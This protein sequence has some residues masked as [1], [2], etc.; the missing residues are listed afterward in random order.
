[1]NHS[2]E[3]TPI[4]R[5]LGAMN[6][7]LIH[8]AIDYHLWNELPHLH[9]LDQQLI[10][11]IQQKMGNN[12]TYYRWHT[13]GD[14]KVRDSH[15]ANDGKIFLWKEPPA[16]GHP[17]EDYNCRCWAEPLDVKEYAEQTL[18]SAVND[19]P[20]KWTDIDFW[21]HYQ[22]GS[23]R[24][25]TLS[26]TGYL[27]DVIEHYSDRLGIYDRVNEQIVEEAR[28]KEEGAFT[29]KFNNNYP[30][31]SVL[32]SFGE[33]TVSGKFNGDVRKIK[34]NGID[35]LVINGIVDYEFSDRFEDPFEKVERT[36]IL[37]NVSREEAERIVGDDADEH[38]EPF[39][40]EDQWK[41]KF[42]ATAL[43]LKE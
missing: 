33:S 13:Q 38:G 42:N 41:T 25:I 3:Y 20:Q 32:Y 23:G 26:E 21:D 10:Q 8:K 22:E 31:E 30:F 37:E 4:I 14:D 11:L 39:G 34:E 29:Y 15:V 9:A 24:D 18:I 12:S 40:I 7:Y 16:T 5:N 36:Q 35:Y 19:N 1:M 2:S 28:K 27:G 6:Q 43:L 17:G